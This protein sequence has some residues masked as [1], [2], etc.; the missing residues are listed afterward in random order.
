MVEHRI[1]ESEIFF[2]PFPQQDEKHPSVS[3]EL[4]KMSN[5]Q[6]SQSAIVHKMNSSVGIQPFLRES[7][8]EMF[9][10]IRPSCG[11]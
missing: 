9:S 6:A 2:V 7:E 8:S 1:A 5:H 3:I 11:P 4:S 10:E